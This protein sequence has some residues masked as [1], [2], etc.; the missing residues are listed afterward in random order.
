[1]IFAL[2]RTP[3]T[4]VP[5]FHIAPD[6]LSLPLTVMHFAT[7]FPRKPN[8]HASLPI[9]YVGRTF[10][11]PGQ[12]FRRQNVRKKLSAVSC[13][14]EGRSVLLVDDSIV[15]GTTS[16]E[17]VRIVKEAGARKVFFCSASPPVSGLGA[18]L[19]TVWRGIC[20]YSTSCC[21]HWGASV[22]GGGALLQARLEA[23]SVLAIIVRK[24]LSGR[25]LT[26]LDRVNSCLA[27]SSWRYSRMGLLSYFERRSLVMFWCT[28]GLVF[29]CFSPR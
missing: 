25:H 9:R 2:Y 19:W 13:V 21:R 16:R 20:G 12:S 22:G 15:R 8:L 1:M 14:L 26:S 7:W 24:Y 10:I 11:M 4:S 6:A 23:G 3:I 29:I 5:T 17:I 18:E 28:L 27:Q